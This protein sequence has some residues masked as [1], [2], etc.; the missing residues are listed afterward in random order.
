MSTS[1]LRAALVGL[2]DVAW[3]Y[4]AAA[5]PGRATTHLESYRALGIAC[6]AGCDASAAAAR[7]FSAATGIRAYPDPRAMLQAEPV[8]LVSICSPDELHFEHARIALEA[9]VRRIW[10]EKPPTATATA[11][12]E[13]VALA[14]RHGATV[15]VNFFRRYHPCFERVKAMVTGEALGRAHRIELRYSRGLL[16]NGIHQLDL[17]HFITA[18]SLSFDVDAATPGGDERHAD[19]FLH[20]DSLRVELSGALLPYHVQETDVLCERGRIRAT[21]GGGAL[22]IDRAAPNP[23]YPGFSRLEL[24]PAPEFDEGNPGD[25]FPEV[26]ADLIASH[27]RKQAPRSHLGTAL[28]SMQL[29]ENIMQQAHGDTRRRG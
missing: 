17:L 21:Q 29:Y 11:T 15:A 28:R 14:Q 3:G 19:A 2:G 1:G 6:V 23:D 13:L 9:G 8:D 16:A 18:D 10:L 5:R 26:L 7:R 27:D 25:R 4:P 22:W 20:S 24:A 12:R